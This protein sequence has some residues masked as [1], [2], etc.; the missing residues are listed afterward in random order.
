M[1]TASDRPQLLP[2]ASPLILETISYLN[3][4][5]T[6]ILSATEGASQEMDDPQYARELLRDAQAAARRAAADLAR[7]MC[8]VEWSIPDSEDDLEDMLAE[9]KTVE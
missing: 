9:L 4:A 8:I 6:V 7:L 1:T 2:W 3:S 5:L